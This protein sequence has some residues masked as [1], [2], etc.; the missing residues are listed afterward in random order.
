M[1][2]QTFKR[3]K[4]AYLVLV[5]ALMVPLIGMGAL[6]ID[7][8]RLYVMRSE[9][10]NAADAAAIAAAMEL[11]KGPNARARAENAAR[12][13][14]QHDSK[15]AEVS[16]LLGVNIRLEFFCAIG[17]QYDPLPKQIKHFCAND[18]VNGRS[19]ATSDVETSYVRVNL[20]PNDAN[21]AYS[22]QL[23]FLPALS[24]A[25]NQV[26]SRA[27]LRATATAG[28]NLYICEFPPMMLCNPFEE[29]GLAFQDE[30][31]PGDQIILKQQGSS[32]WAPGNFGFLQPDNTPGGGA[33]ELSRFLADENLSGCKTPIFTTST[34]SMTNQTAN[35]LN[36]RFDMY[37]NPGF[38]RADAPDN[39]P[40]APNVI[41]FPR[42]QTWRSIDDRFG[43]GDWDRDNYF[44]TYHDWQMHGRPGGWAD[45]TRWDIY[46][47]SIAENKL[48]SKFPLLPSNTDTTYDGIPNPDHLYIGEYAPPP[49][50]PDRRALLVAVANCQ[51][52]EI[53]GQTTFPLINPTE[54]FARLFLT[55]HV[56]QP[57]GADILAEYLEWASAESRSNIHV[58]V[59]LYE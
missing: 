22:L 45:M 54:G 19:L 2:L 15:F 17:A 44:A 1:R 3:Q 33:S 18:Y 41:N 51:A 30:M 29:T 34:G 46:N 37:S 13:L 59:Q 28:R 9:M 5:G 25:L 16:N 31:I 26:D 38:G 4:G 58:D 36:T 12:N 43:H 40:P 50:V 49:S 20:E 56:R 10:Q 6:A 23:L 53:S 48:P 32:Q 8:G 11:N 42:D 27:S 35:A 55:E 14:L 57:P 47:W 21:R 52:H 7:L 24:T 39:W